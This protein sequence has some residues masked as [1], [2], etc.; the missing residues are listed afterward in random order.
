MGPKIFL[1]PSNTNSVEKE[2]SEGMKAASTDRQAPVTNSVVGSTVDEAI[3]SDKESRAPYCNLMNFVQINLHHSRT[4]SVALVDLLSRSNIVCALIQEPW[5]DNKFKIC[6]LN[7][8]D[9]VLC[10]KKV[11]GRKNRSCILIKKDVKFFFLDNYSDEDFTAVVLERRVGKS[12]CLCSAYCPY[13]ELENFPSQNFVRAAKE[14]KWICIVGCDSNGHHTQWGSRDNNVRGE[15]FFNYILRSSLALCNKGNEATFFNKTCNTVVDVTLISSGYINL[16]YNWRVSKEASLSDHAWILFSIRLDVEKEVP[17][18]N[19]QK[20]NW[21]KFSEAFTNTLP[22]PPEEIKTSDDL[23]RAV[24]DLT[25]A[26]VSSFEKSLPKSHLG[27]R[28]KKK[29]PWWNDEISTCM[30]DARSAMNKAKFSGDADSWEEYKKKNRNLKRVIRRNKRASWKSFCDSITSNNEASR[31]RKIMSKGPNIIGSL[32]MDGDKW[33]E[34]S[35]DILNELM[36]THFPGCVDEIVDKHDFVQSNSVHSSLSTEELDRIFSKDKIDWAI[37]SFSPFKAHGAD[38]IIPK[39]LQVVSQT[40]LDWLAM[41]FKASLHLGII[42]KA[43][44]KVRVVFI[45]KSG[46]TSHSTAKD[47]RPI[48]LSSFLLKTMER[49]VD[50]E[51]RLKIPKGLLSNSQ[52]AYMKGKSTETALHEVVGYIEKGMK[53]K[54]YVLAAF[55]DIE[56]AFN[57]VKTE[58]IKKALEYVRVP[59]GFINWI[60]TMLITR[61]VTSEIG[62]RSCNKTVRRGTPQGGVISPLLWLLVV[63]MILKSL[64]ESG[65]KIVAYAD[66]LVVLIKGKKRFLNTLSELMEGTLAKL[67]GWACQ[68]GLGVNP[69]KTELMLFTN[70]HKL[71]IFKTPALAGETLKISEYAKY[72][73]VIL[74]RKLNWSRNL[75]ER[76]KKANN[77]LY[78]CKK[79]IGTNWGFSPKV[80][81]WIYTSVV[82]PILTYGCLVWWKATDK[83]Y[84]K[85][86]LRSVQRLACLLISGALKSTSTDSLDITLGFTPIDLF[87]RSLAAKSAIRLQSLDCFKSYTYGHGSILHEMG[88]EPFDSSSDYMTSLFDFEIPFMTTFPSR[89]EWESKQVTNEF[90]ISVFTDGSKMDCGTGSGVFVSA[91]NIEESY[92]LND[93]NSVF[94]AEVVAVIKAAELLENKDIQNK[95]IAI[96]IDSHAA[97]RAIASRQ[98]KSRVVLNCRAVLKR[99]CDRNSITLCWVPGHSGHE[100]NEKADFLARKGSESVSQETVADVF[101]PISSLFSTIDRVT[102]ASAE[103]R[104][105]ESDHSLCTKLFFPSYDAGKTKFLINESRRGL[106]SLIGI[107]TGHNMLGSHAKRLRL[108]TDDTCRYCSSLDCSEDTQHILCQCDGVAKTRHFIFGT[109][110]FDVEEDLSNIGLYDLKRFFARI[111]CDPRAVNSA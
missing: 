51:I 3:V 94:Q 25:R 11:E 6:G 54:E 92:K 90:Q 73:G 14:N 27:R 33:A 21:E 7:I 42:P 108:T 29:P 32:R 84:L 63:N 105:K 35:E 88:V 68:N 4:A 28:G 111:G 22:K 85:N 40:I 91:L 34:S 99:L 102:K 13:E 62:S 52:H 31:L 26:L 109:F 17:F 15:L 59:E 65:V 19:P 95:S 64:E 57:N 83:R 50:L 12:I 97:I 101:N 107:V 30:R 23:N 44:Q 76:I 93:E 43:W 47:F 8:K 66:D 60:N 104:W 72:L 48:S 81:Y 67:H 46:K 96:F 10:Y 87:V 45:P 71:P 2:K 78:I 20:A 5:V 49:L 103:N 79:C 37:N 69:A 53:D 58:S 106:R 56:G 86:K 41:I 24:N 100:G 16:V 1:N 74:D 36:N 75:N 89:E 38:G 18:V 61:V 9:F 55:L 98:I 39:M 82:R 77:A 110:F 70:E 80:C